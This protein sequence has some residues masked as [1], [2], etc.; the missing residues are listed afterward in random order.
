VVGG[1]GVVQMQDGLNNWQPLTDPGTVDITAFSVT[2]VV[3]ALTNDLSRYCPCL[4]KLTCTAADMTDVTRNPL[5]PRTMTIRSYQVAL[6]GRAV[7][8]AAI[9]RTINENVRVRN[10]V[11]SG[12]CPAP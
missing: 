5:G 11:L 6:T 9:V 10:P 7:G 4:F 12:G 2:A 3:P 8:D 1:I